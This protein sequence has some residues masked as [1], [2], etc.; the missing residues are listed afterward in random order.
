LKN[1]FR[2]FVGRRFLFG[3][4]AA[5]LALATSGDARSAAAQ[6]QPVPLAAWDF[7]RGAVGTQGWAATHDVA[8]PLRATDAG[9]VITRTGPDPYL[10]GPAR[11]LPPGQPLWLRV[12]LKS[13]QSG[14]A[15]V[16]YFNTVAT[17]ANS[18][19][20]PV[21][22]GA[23][24]QNVRVPLPP[25]GPGFR[26][27]LDPPG[28]DT[29]TVTLA[30][31]SLAPRVLLK[32]PAAWPG[33]VPLAV[34]KNA[35]SLTSADLRLVH[36]PH[37]WN[38]FALSV[39][40]ENMAMGHSRPLVGYLSRGRV[41]WLPLAERAR[42][43]VARDAGTGAL[44]A[45]ATFRDDDGADW[46]L[47]QQ[48]APSAAGTIAVETRVTVSRPRNV[49]YLPLLIVLPGGGNNGFGT[50]KN[51]ALLAG[52]EYLDAPD[53]SSSEA[54]VI[55][56]GA[57]RQV[58]DTINVTFPLMVVQAKGRYVGLIW[59]KQR[60]VSALFDSPDRIFKSG[61]HALGLL[62][63]GANGPEDR[64]P[65]SLLPYDGTPIMPS[66]PLV[67]RAT[68]IGGKGDSVVPAVRQYVA[69]H[70]LPPVPK[71]VK[72]NTLALLAA[73][74]LDSQVR[75]PGNVFRHAYPGNFAAQPAADAAVFQDWLAAKTRDASAARRLAD[76]A[77]AALV[78]V[79][80]A[81]RNASGVSHIRPPVASLVFGHVEANAERAR[82]AA[83]GLLA[84]F[85]PD[86]SVRYRKTADRPDYGRTHFAPDANGLT[87]Q[88]VASLLENAAVC[89][90]AV[91]IGEGLKRLRA[92][93]KFTNTVP[94]GAQ[95]W[96]V[97]LHTPDILAAAYPVRAYTLG[98]ELTGDA[99]FLDQA[100]Y[101]AWTGLPFVYLADPG[102]RPVGVYASIAVLACMPASR[103]WAR[104]TGKR[105]FGSAYPCSGAAWSTPTR[106]T[107]SFAGTLPARG[108][109]SPMASPRRA[110]SKR[111]RSAATPPARVC[112]PT[113]SRCAPKSATMLPSIQARFWPAPSACSNPARNSTTFARSA[114]AERAALVLGTTPTKLACRLLFVA[115]R[116]VR[117][118]VRGALK[119]TT[120]TVLRRNRASVAFLLVGGGFVVVSCAC[121][122]LPPIRFFGRF[123][124][125]PSFAFPAWPA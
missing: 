83:R 98:Y 12:R 47:R 31:L 95:T 77:R 97:P 44:V 6:E 75:Q 115:G 107:G 124:S 86:N 81:E 117:V 73:G 79:A 13:D 27:R 22:A 9:L 32:E 114:K 103:C 89:G 50:A 56:P 33:P 85:E 122:F 108:S 70:S 2:N 39:A 112:S 99:H 87:A 30:G 29:G 80:P 100:R 17:E 61:G 11:D 91:L 64:A 76:A 59:E 104:R 49:V 60:T 3:A 68:L 101:W 1:D 21:P 45:R 116:F 65:G 52:V 55:G 34:N 37:Q 15:Q 26:L 40:G 16:F 78:P 36:S 69:L 111:G 92:L 72:D 71:V 125:A 54:D 67:L 94:R 5:V 109:R 120:T 18:V 23:A 118:R 113:Q 88:V 119:D 14:M 96:E 123:P 58:T 84:R 8:S 110:C 28:R 24:W 57:K 19:Q 51:Q 102:T 62:F 43:S 53:A 105:R 93:D 20:F 63:P 66:A 41:R 25:L 35:L 121:S 46:D 10:V 42:V 82:E 38:G 74:W 48:F 90:D 106:C 7:T 4:V